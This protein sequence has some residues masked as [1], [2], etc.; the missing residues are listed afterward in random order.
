MT[1]Q[2]NDLWK[3]LRQG[4]EQA[5]RELFECHYAVLCHFATQFVHD[6]FTAEALVGDVFYTLWERRNTLDVH[7]SMR[8]YLLRAV[9]NRCLNHLEAFNNKRMQR[10]SSL[11]AAQLERLM[12]EDYQ[13]RLL[14]LEDEVEKAVSQLPEHTREVF[15][16]SREG[17]LK[18]EE[19]AR[20]MGISVN[21][22]KFH[23]KKA[24]SL[25]RKY[26]SNYLT[27]ALL[28]FHFHS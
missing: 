4:D 10:F 11:S 28:L 15:E 17:H 23:I 5:W 13:G 22:V 3:T 2:G 19:I 18:Y 27:V 20:Q 1:G 12:L 6:R 8:T 14:E 9:R 24:L 25:L 16:K 26:L 21:T 7:E